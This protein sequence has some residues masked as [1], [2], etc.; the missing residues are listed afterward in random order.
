MQLAAKMTAVNSAEWVA[1]SK[2]GNPL[3]EG[4]FHQKMRI[5]SLSKLL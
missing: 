4:E 5:V 1:I 2:L 3:I